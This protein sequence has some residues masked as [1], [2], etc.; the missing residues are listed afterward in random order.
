MRFSAKTI[1]IA[2]VIVIAVA[3]TILYFWYQGRASESGRYDAFAQCLAQKNATMYGTY[4]C[5]HCENQKKKF[6]SS[7]QYVPYVECAIRGS[8][9]QAKACTDAGINGYP[10][11]IFAD[12]SRVAG[13]VSLKAL[14]EKTECALP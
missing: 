7:F 8:R 3:L 6:G 12:G 4:W 13:E 1:Q 10:T 5:P 11:W 9:E 14:G 2:G